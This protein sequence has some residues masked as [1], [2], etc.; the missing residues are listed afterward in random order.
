M[1]KDN[2]TL[3]CRVKTF[4]QTR[5]WSQEQLAER[6]GVR[7]QAIYDIESGRYLPNTAVALRLARQFSCTVEDLFMEDAGDRVQPICLTDASPPKS[8]R[9]AVAS[10]RERLVGFSLDGPGSLV[11]GLRPADG[12]LTKDGRMVALFGSRDLVD[13]TVLLRGCDPAFEILA[14]HLRRA[15]P[16]SAMLCRF[17]SSQAALQGLADGVAHAAG[18]H[19]HN[20]GDQE[21][22]VELVKRVCSGCP[23]LVIGFSVIEEGLVVA[24]GNPLAIGGLVDLT[25]PKLRLVNREP[26]A[27]LRTLLDDQLAEAGIPPQAVNG[28]HRQVT[29]HTAGAQQVA[30]D[31]AD[32]ALGFRTVAEAFGLD[33]VPLAVARC[34]LVVPKDLVDH[35]GIKI[36]LDVLQSEPLRREM[37]CLPGYD[38]KAAGRLIAEVQG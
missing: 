33:F 9:V 29:N 34:D 18:T 19:L 17:A 26:G 32:A 25:R 5:G 22:N 11:E 3:R 15:S 16:E 4:R 30:F 21:A 1:A 14:A 12:L 38:A 13:R 10:V 23:A 36:M 7:R 6:I 27:A 35:P 8:K 24:P 20:R 2:F 31:A 28:Y 37:A